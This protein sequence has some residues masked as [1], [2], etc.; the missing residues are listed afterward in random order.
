MPSSDLFDNVNPVVLAVIAIAFAALTFSERLAQLEGKFRWIGASARWWSNRQIRKVRRDNLLERT[1]RR[2]RD[3]A[4][5]SLDDRYRALN[6]RVD[7]LTEA[8]Q[9]QRDDHDDELEAARLEHREDIRKT[10]EE[11]N[12]EMAS[13]RRELER[14]NEFI[15]RLFQWGH[16]ARAKAALGG[17]DIDPM[18]ENGSN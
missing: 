3:E 15:V 8:M 10:R 14:K 4:Y 13:M 5:A 7:Q 1:R 6:I 16:S 11:H 17:I 2:A 18:P 12:E 9:K